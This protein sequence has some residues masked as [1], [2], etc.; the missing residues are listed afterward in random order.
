MKWIAV[1]ALCLSIP[2]AEAGRF[3]S[4]ELKQKFAESEVLLKNLSEL[5]REHDVTCAAQGKI[6]VFVPK[7]IKKIKYVARCGGFKFK[8]SASFK[9]AKNP[10]FILDTVKV[11][12]KGRTIIINPEESFSSDPFLE[13]YKKSQLVREIRHFTENNYQVVCKEGRVRKGTIGGKANYFYFAKCKSD[14]TSVNIKIKSR[15]RVL[16]ENYFAF[17]LT[18][19]KLSF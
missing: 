10:N 3:N 12:N 5:E 15:V 8:I 19:Y 16:G 14:T 9:D 17:G 6:T 18:K 7:L 2:M 4:K 11:W 13:A 1:M